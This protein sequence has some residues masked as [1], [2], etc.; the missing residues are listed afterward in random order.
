VGR[1][2]RDGVSLTGFTSTPE[3]P[4]D[5]AV[6]LAHGFSNHVWT[7]PIQ[8]IASRLARRFGIVA[9]S[10]RG[11]RGSSGR[12]SVGPAEV[13]DIAAGVELARELG[14]AKVATVGFSMGAAVSLLHA[15]ENVDGDVDVVDA[16][17]SVS[18]PS[19]WY[20]RQTAAMR[21]VHWL[22]E[23][24]HARLLAP[25]LGVRVEQP[26]ALLPV[27]PIEVV[28]R[29][30]TPLLVVHGDRDH[31][32]P[33]EHG[34]ALHRASGRSELWLEHGMAHAESA[35]TPGLADRIGDWLNR[36]CGRTSH[37]ETSTR[38]VA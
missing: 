1:I 8:R 22:I 18:S 26:W 25:L 23:A 2:T 5:L 35:V 15:S 3:T 33:A 10:F 24:P 19:R 11:H 31:Y 32:F 38:A 17:V 12:T 9:L 13:R 29:I 37:E 21:R 28:H 14:Y 27:S 20:V 4:S 30:E 6:V 34:E 16:T 7:V 36:T